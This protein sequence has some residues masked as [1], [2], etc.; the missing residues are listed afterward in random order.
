M[1]TIYSMKNGIHGA[2][3]VCTVFFYNIMQK[4]SQIYFDLIVTFVLKKFSDV[5]LMLVLSVKTKK[6]YYQ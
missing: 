1:N 3:L 6:Y 5:L 2:Y 4:N